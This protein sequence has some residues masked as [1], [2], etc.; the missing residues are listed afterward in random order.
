M[1]GLSQEHQKQIRERKR[2]YFDLIRDT[3]DML[4]A[5]GKMS[6]RDTTVAAFSIFG[7]IMWLP[8]W[9][10]PRGSKPDEHI[11]AELKRSILYGVLGTK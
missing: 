4:I 8:R 7:A 9:Y 10:D 6:P 1:A 2:G 3:L 5:E 11:I